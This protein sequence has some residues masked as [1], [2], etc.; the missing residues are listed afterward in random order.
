MSGSTPATG[1]LQPFVPLDARSVVLA[2]QPLPTDTVALGSPSTGS[3]EL[4][5]MASAEVGLWEMSEGGVFDTETDEVFVVLSGH[6]VVT[7]LD[8]VEPR[9]IALNPGTICR[10]S[11]GMRTR[12]D[13]T[14]ALRKLY[15]IGAPLE[16]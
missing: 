13:V 11:A 8:G 12:W 4:L 3:E 15:I 16:A 9:T 14:S 1:I 7:L 6:A 10:L 2:H 5:R